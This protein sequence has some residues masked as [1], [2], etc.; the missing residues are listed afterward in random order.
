MKKIIAIL[1]V[2]MTVLALAACGSQN[3]AE[4]DGTAAETEKPA[5]TDS[6]L[7]TLT[8]GV[9]SLAEN[10]AAADAFTKAT[11][12]FEIYLYEPVAVLGSMQENGDTVYSYLCRGQGPVSGTVPEYAIVNVTVEEDGEASVTGTSSVVEIAGEGKVGA[13]DSNPGDFRLDKNPKV[14]TAFETATAEITD[15]VYEPIAFVG[16]QVV[17][18][19][20]YA[21]FCAKA[22][23]GQDAEKSFCVLTI[24]ADL[25]GHAEITEI[26]DTDIFIK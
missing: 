4:G 25:E 24:Y 3:G 9:Y 15:T 13:W 7:Y 2:I 5:K 16:S 1:L 26:K 8:D 23:A 12:K 14:Q 20:N 22:P 18:G 19:K 21:V 6:G 11:E 10:K 17:A